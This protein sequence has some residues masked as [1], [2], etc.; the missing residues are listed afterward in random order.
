MPGAVAARVVLPDPLSPHS[1]ML[2]CMFSAD[3][4]IIDM[5]P[6]TRAASLIVVFSIRQ[7]CNALVCCLYHIE[8]CIEHIL[9]RHTLNF[10]YHYTELAD[11]TIGFYFVECCHNHSSLV[12][13]ASSRVSNMPR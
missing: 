2:S 3:G 12:A 1:N 13:T 9:E 5:P 7:V 6:A 8:H 4:G 10:L 11:C